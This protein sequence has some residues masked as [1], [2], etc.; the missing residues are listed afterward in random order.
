M[1]FLLC[2]TYYLVFKIGPVLCHFSGI[3]SSSS[4]VHCSFSGHSHRIYNITVD[5]N[6]AVHIEYS[7]FYVEVISFFLIDAISK[8]L[9]LIGTK[10]LKMNSLFVHMN[11]NTGRNNYFHLVTA[12][13]D[14]L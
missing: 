2:V 9:F 5:K 4:E 7:S 14:I 6:R 11:P 3:A 8:I 12:P 10:D 1:L 13:Y